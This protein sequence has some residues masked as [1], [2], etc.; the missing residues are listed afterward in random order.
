MK[1]NL[2][3]ELKKRLV[4]L[5]WPL[6]IETALIMLIGSVDTIM[7]AR[8]SNNASGAVGVGNQVIGLFNLLFMIVSVGTSILASQFIGAKINQKVSQ[9]TLLSILVNFIMGF[10]GMIVLLIFNEPLLKLLQLN[11]ELLEYG[12]TY[13]RIVAFGS[14]FQA[15]TFS[16]GAIIRSYGFTKT[17]MKASLIANGINIVL[18]YVFIF[19]IPALNIPQMGVAGAAIATLIAKAVHF[20]ILI[21]VLF[22]VVDRSL[23]FKLLKPFPK[24]VLKDII[25]IGL[26][27]VG[28]NM[29]Y[30]LSQLVITGFITSIGVIALNTM[31]FYL[32]VAMFIYVFTVAISNAASIMV[33]NLTGEDRG[34][35][36][37]QLGKYS[38]KIS[39]IITVS[40]NLLYI[41]LI[42]PLIR[43]FTDNAEIIELAKIIVIIDLFLEVGRAVNIL[44][45]NALK[46]SGDIRFPV[47]FAVI[48]SWSIMIPLAYVLGIALEFGLVGIWMAMAL[49]E[50]IRGTILTF[51]WMS[52]K[53][54]NK[55]FVTH[56]R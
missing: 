24:K 34:E 55:S 21:Y 45:G 9:V 5:A 35:D 25:D 49:D 31:T 41:I 3:P 42:I 44:Y 17:G 23:S 38:T 14:V 4:T 1:T 7:I 52:K 15:I 30:S 50:I 8:F 51:R 43:I 37:Y 20:G 19:G 10:L 26:P 28:E 36:V 33:G 12:K 56:H 53:W 13:V 39:V 6:F 2:S 29:S 48:I 32:T 11:S 46:A 18:D 54:Q 47:F 40:M 27:S 22:R 16:A